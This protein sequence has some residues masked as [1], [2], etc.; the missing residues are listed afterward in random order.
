[1]TLA[2][3]RSGRSAALLS[4]ALLSSVMVALG[5]LAGTAPATAAPAEPRTAVIVTLVPGADAAVESLRAAGMGGAVSHVYRSALN[6]FAVALPARAIAALE[7]SPL[8]SSVEPDVVVSVSSTESNAP[9]GLDRIDQHARPL[10]GRYTYSRT[11]SGVTAYVVDTGIAPGKDFEDGLGAGTTVI[12]DGNGTRD[13]NGHGTHVAGTLGG[14]TYGVAKEVTL[15]PVRVLDC[16]GYGT[17][18]GLIAGLDWVVAHHRAGRPAVAN[19]SLSGE[20]NASLDAAVARVIADGVT[21]AIAAGNDG[22]NACN[23]SPGRVPG[24]LTAG[25]TDRSDRR[26]SFSNTGSCVDLFAPGVDVTS[27]WPGGTQTISGTSM[28][29]PHVAGVAALVLA[30]HR[31][32]LPA[33]VAAEVLRLSTPNVVAARGTGSPN[34]LLYAPPG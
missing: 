9:W 19:L 28:A 20:R 4:S 1:M 5:V 25:A 21:V 3:R 14:Q 26:A 34:R 27:D 15:V 11:G 13:C 17:T 31:T 22:A 29:S 8:V 32:W 10:D 2:G 16:G 33:A 30:A 24:A 18:S 6:G 12:K 7:R 23:F